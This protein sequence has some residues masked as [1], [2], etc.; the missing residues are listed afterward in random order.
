MG[1]KNLIRL[2]EALAVNRDKFSTCY[3]D[4]IPEKLMKE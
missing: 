4:Y 2:E 1:F 3:I